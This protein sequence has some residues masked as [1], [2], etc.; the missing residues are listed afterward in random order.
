MVRERVKQEIKQMKS[1]INNPMEEAPDTSQ[2]QGKRQNVRVGEGE[3]ERSRGEDERA[4]EDDDSD[5]E[6]QEEEELTLIELS[7]IDGAELTPE[8]MS[9]FKLL[10]LHT[11]RPVL[12]VGHLILQGEAD[13]VTGTAMFFTEQTPEEA[14]AVSRPHP[15][16]APLTSPSPPPPLSLPTGPG[17]PHPDFDPVFSRTSEKTLVYADKCQR[18]LKMKRIFIK[19][20]K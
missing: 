8:A 12:Q 13:S 4:E 20:N 11:P 7:G 19:E 2:E 10:G 5:Y 3:N 1:E 15:I 14:A 9:H 6:W 17:F 18:L 16:L